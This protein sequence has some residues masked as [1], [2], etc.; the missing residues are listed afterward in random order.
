VGMEFLLE[1]VQTLEI[2]ELVP[3]QGDFDIIG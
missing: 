3:F 2:V 1:L